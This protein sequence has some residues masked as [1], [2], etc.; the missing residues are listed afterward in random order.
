VSK[1]LIV[2]QLN[3]NIV[4]ALYE[5]GQMIQ[6]NVDPV[7]DV[8]LLGNIYVGKVKNIVKNINAA[9]VEIEDKQ[10]CYLSLAEATSP[11]YITKANEKICIGDEFLVQISKEDVKTKAPV[12]TTNISFTGKYMVLVHK[13]GRLGISS[14]I[15]DEGERKRLKKIV[16][17]YFSDDYGLVIRTNAQEAEEGLIVE[18]LK[19]LVAE[20]RRVV[21]QGVYRSRFSLVYRTPRAYLCAIRDSFSRDIEAIIT[22]DNQLFEQMQEYLRMNQQE[23]LDKLR[24]YEDKMLPLDKLYSI[25]HKLSNAL[26]EKVWL[27]CGGTLII[28][29]TEALTVIDVNTGKAVTKK[30]QVQETFLKVNLEAAKEIAKQIRLRN[31]SGIIIVDFIDM[32]ANKDKKL[33][34]DTLEGYLKT[35]PIKTTLV[36]MTALNLVEIT[37]KKV[38]KPL[39]EQ[40]KQEE[41]AHD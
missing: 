6:V 30:K 28:Q 25:E 39:L 13:K 24:L 20:Y 36:D 14:K 31:L 16:S 10:M 26:R 17:P 12:C 8:S 40:M 33:L 27:D 37:R 21:E 38:R 2:K 23:D 29:P 1:K 4:S 18:E 34:M 35:D 11:I 19:S 7:E 9:F 5:E 3:H 32:E 41:T 15:E 22:D